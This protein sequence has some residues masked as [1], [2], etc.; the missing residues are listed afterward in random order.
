M[1]IPREIWSYLLWQLPGW[2]LAVVILMALNA[3]VGLPGWAGV[4]LFFL[5]VAKD[6]L[7]FPFMREA[8]RPSG[9]GRERLIGAR[10]HAVDGLA[11]SGYVRLNG[12]LWRAEV[13]ERGKAIPAGNPVVV[14]DAR[15]LTLIVEEEDRG[16]PHERSAI[17][18]GR[19]LPK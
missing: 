12:E 1:R 11:P 14:R 8:F 2:G 3:L 18:P 10:G 9:S 17:D 13:G 7:M 15:G 5:V 19:M 4:V 6:V 16:T